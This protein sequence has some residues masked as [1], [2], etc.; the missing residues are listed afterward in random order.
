[1]TARRRPARPASRHDARRNRLRGVCS[2]SNRRHA[3]L[4]ERSAAAVYWR[5]ASRVRRRSGSTALRSTV[6]T[7]TASPTFRSGRICRRVIHFVRRELAD[8]EV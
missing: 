2:S 5:S 6:D 1:M 4:P 8:A 3:P 7:T